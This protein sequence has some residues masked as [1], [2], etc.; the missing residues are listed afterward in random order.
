MEGGE[1]LGSGQAHLAADRFVTSDG[2]A[3]RGGGPRVH[4]GELLGSG[5]AHLVADRLVA[6]NG[7]ERFGGGVGVVLGELLGRVNTVLVVFVHVC[8]GFRYTISSVI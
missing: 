6:G 8:V 1:Q 4:V 5:Q 2:Q 3:G 7:G